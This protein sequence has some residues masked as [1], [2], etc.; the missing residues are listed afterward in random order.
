DPNTPDHVGTLLAS[1]GK[2]SFCLIDIDHYSGR[3]Y[4]DGDGNSHTYPVIPNSPA[5]G[6]YESCGNVMQGISPGWAD[7]Y[8]AGLADQWIDITG[9]GLTGGPPY[10]LQDVL[11]PDNHI[12]ES[13]ESNNVTNVVI[14]IDG[15]PAGPTVQSVTPTG[16]ISGTVSSAQV[17]F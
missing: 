16:G 4:T 14:T 10:I 2:T 1:G 17:T 9:L 12:L 13:N 5:S 6:F 8:T 15:L 3:T 7:V 11:D